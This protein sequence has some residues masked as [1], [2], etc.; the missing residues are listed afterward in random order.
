MK[1]YFG[2]LA[3]LILAPGCQEFTSES[4]TGALSEPDDCLRSTSAERI[5][6]DISA[7]PAAR[8]KSPEVSDAALQLQLCRSW[9]AARPLC[10]PLGG[11]RDP[12]N[13]HL[14]TIC[15][16]LYFEGEFIRAFLRGSPETTSAC[17]RFLESEWA[18]NPGEFS[19]AGIDKFCAAIPGVRSTEPFCSRVGPITSSRS[20]A[21][22]SGKCA[23]I[24]R[25]F[26]GDDE[27]CR[28]LETSRYEQD[29][30]LNAPLCREF[31]ALRRAVDHG[32]DA[33]RCKSS[34]FCLWA[35]GRPFD[36]G[37]HESRL[38]SAY[39]SDRRRARHK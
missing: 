24:V 12:S 30:E 13:V 22:W 27:L 39:C 11:L 21:Y 1:H 23:V 25:S 20:A 6:S 14:T 26:L 32:D 15:R 31:A 34:G 18:D 17:V 16:H 33:G 38:R 3:L 37:G 4:T 8:G 10:Q 35:L 36:C 9:S 2:V 19:R 5:L 29:L 28:R 7:E